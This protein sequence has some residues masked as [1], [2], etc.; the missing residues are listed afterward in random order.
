MDG[1]RLIMYSRL[2]TPFPSYLFLPFPTLLSHFVLSAL[3]FLQ[4]W[5]DFCHSLINT[6]HLASPIHFFLDP[7]FLF[8]LNL[9]PPFP[10]RCRSAIFF[11]QEF[12]QFYT[13]NI[14][15]TDNCP[16]FRDVIKKDSR[17][18][19]LRDKN[20]AAHGKI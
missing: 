17:T 10:F 16:L 7:S 18:L 13:I 11:F 5:T 4:K 15:M 8:T 19:S 1:S 20:H 2:N 9:P 14:W 6:R 3:N 12:I